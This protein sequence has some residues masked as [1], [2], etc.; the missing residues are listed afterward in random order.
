MNKKLALIT[1]AALVL[2]IYPIQSATA[3]IE[4]VYVDLFFNIGAVDELTVTLLGESAVTSGAL[5]GTATPAN[6]EFN[7]SGDTLWQNAS[8]MGGSTQ[9]VTNPILSLDNTGTTNFQINISIN[10]S[11]P[12][13]T[14]NMNL[15]FINDSS[16]YDIS[17]LIPKTDGIEVNT[18]NWTIDHS[19]TPAEAT[20]GLWLYGN[21]SGCADNDDTSRRFTIYAKTV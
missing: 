18:T 19:F 7:V 16:P 10:A 5:P 4:A 13:G 8:V 15:T 21:F 20:Q 12:T 1:F 14:C 3:V 2:L 6:I 11:T 9:D 17:G